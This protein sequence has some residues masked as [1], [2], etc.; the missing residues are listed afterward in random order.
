MNLLVDYVISTNKT[1]ADEQSF[2]NSEHLFFKAIYVT[3]ICKAIPKSL[4][5]LVVIRR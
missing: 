5:V 4:S 2:N 1:I 3:F